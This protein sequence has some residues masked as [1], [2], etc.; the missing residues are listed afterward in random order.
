[1]VIGPGM[2]NVETISSPRISRVRPINDA[3][4]NMAFTMFRLVTGARSVSWLS[5]LAAAEATLCSSCAMRY[6]FRAFQSAIV[7]LHSAFTSHKSCVGF[8]GGIEGI[9][10]WSF[11]TS[12]AS[13]RALASSV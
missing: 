8:F 2:L 6:C 13:A 7:A 12:S 10:T 3:L 9:T 11:L 5:W 1:M 4:I